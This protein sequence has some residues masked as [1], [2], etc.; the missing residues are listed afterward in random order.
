MNVIPL[1]C[2]HEFSSIDFAEFP[3]VLSSSCL[4]RNLNLDCKSVV[5]A[6]FL[7]ICLLYNHYNLWNIEWGKNFWNRK[8]RSFLYLVLHIKVPTLLID[9]WKVQFDLKNDF[10]NLKT[11]WKMLLTVHTFKEGTLFRIIWILVT[12]KHVDTFNTS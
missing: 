4:N 8:I 10:S 11:N 12:H 7:S 6:S 5:C 3:N 1:L 9:K 2:L